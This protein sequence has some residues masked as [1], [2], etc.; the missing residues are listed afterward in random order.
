[1]LAAATIALLCFGADSAFVT[2]AA[3]DADI[4]PDATPVTE[5][6]HEVAE[7]QATA[8]RLLRADP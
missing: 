3:R 4:G 8:A 2:L 7:A 1:M 5:S 6:R